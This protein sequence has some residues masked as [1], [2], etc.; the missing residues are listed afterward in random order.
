MPPRRP[1]SPLALE[2]CSPLASET[3]DHGLACSD[4]ELDERQR[5]ARRRR[6]EK[7]GESYL[8][9]TSLFIL[10]AGL[11][12]PLDKCWDN[13]WKKDRR[14]SAANKNGGDGTDQPVIPETNSRKRRLYQ[15]PTTT[16]R[17]RSSVTPLDSSRAD[18]AHKSAI[19]NKSKD[20][21]PASCTDADG[22]PRHTLV[23]PTDSRWLKKDGVST[24]FQNIDPPTSPTTSVSTR[25]V[26]VN[27]PAQ[28]VSRSVTP[29]LATVGSSKNS[30]STQSKPDFGAQPRTSG[31]SSDGI[32]TSS[33]LKKR[34]G[35]E[36]LHNGDISLRVVSSSSQL[37]KFEYRLK[38][39]SRASPKAYDQA[40]LKSSEDDASRSP[41]DA[42]HKPPP[43]ISKSS[44]ANLSLAP[45]VGTDQTEVMDQHDMGDSL[46][47]TNASNTIENHSLSH[48]DKELAGNLKSGATSE[49]NLPSAQPAPG[50]PLIPDNI[51]SL[52]SIAISKGTST[53]TED[54]NNDQQ[55]STQAAVLMAQKSFQNDLRSPEQSPNLSTRKRRASQGST[56]QSPNQVNITPFHRINTPDR[57]MEDRCS[58][59]TTG[60]AQMMSTQY[61]IDAATPF[62]F[63]TERKKTEY[64]LL[65]SGKDRSNSKKRKTTSFAVSPSESS[66]KH[67]DH[68]EEHTPTVIRQQHQD[69]RDSPSGSNS[70]LPMIL[71]GTTPPT[72]QEGQGAESFNLSQA[73]AE[74]GSWLQQSFEI[75]RDIAHCKTTKL[76]QTHSANI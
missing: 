34:K 14:K 43:D 57:A 18:R 53:R 70:A 69:T 68:D 49:N 64:R 12:G 65:S 19:I 66:P 52:Y 28:S 20:R 4:D 41:I 26:R 72:A 60:G 1:P 45:I 51:T 40:N 15:S 31:I 59:P 13:P 2:T 55:F 38:Q 30:R 74:A 46:T 23:K 54:Q 29:A 67:S 36:Q 71:T 42:F 33:G 39:H 56:N 62:T 63:S 9:G 8:Q 25:H 50:N 37:P 11:R 61:M 27:K 17:S 58:G 16:S 75:N 22:C 3:D 32:Y 7:L 48:L 47:V 24:R 21:V 5:L 10:S 73:I 76:P 44:P 35:N 6:I